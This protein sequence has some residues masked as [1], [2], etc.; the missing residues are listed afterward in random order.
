MRRSGRSMNRKDRD[1]GAEMRLTERT[2]K[3][4]AIWQRNMASEERELVYASAAEMR[5]IRW[6]CGVKLTDRFTCSELRETG[7]E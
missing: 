1:R 2:R 7:E 6:M 5:M 3:L 4:Y